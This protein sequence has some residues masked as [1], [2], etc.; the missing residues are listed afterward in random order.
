MRVRNNHGASVE[1][2]APGEIGEV[3]AGN[4]GVAG[5]IK[6]RML[7]E[8]GPN[9]GRAASPAGA[10]PDRARD[11]EPA[12]VARMRGQFDRAY[13]DL[14]MQLAAAQERIAALERSNAESDA[15]ALARFE[16]VSAQLV[17]RENDLAVARARIAELEAAPAA[18]AT[19]SAEASPA[20]AAGPSKKNKKSDAATE[21]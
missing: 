16:E 19:P 1:G 20:D 8:V 3:N 4:K 6:A 11:G 17:A 10:A 18:P 13:G 14:Q 2:I 21:G 5:F 9:E 15:A 12:E 7:V